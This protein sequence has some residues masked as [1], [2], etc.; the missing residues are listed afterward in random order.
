MKITSIVQSCIILS[1]EF[2]AEI[3]QK[4]HEIDDN[5]QSGLVYHNHVWYSWS[6]YQGEHHSCNLDTSNELVHRNKLYMI[7]QKD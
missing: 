5:C 7:E 1:T 4:S 2:I 6:L 3:G